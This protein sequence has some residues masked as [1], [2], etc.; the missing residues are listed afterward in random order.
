MAV[1]RPTA[2]EK[3]YVANQHKLFALNVI[4][5]VDFLFLKHFFYAKKRR[6]NSLFCLFSWTLRTGISNFATENIIQFLPNR[7]FLL[8]YGM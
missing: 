6:Q 7:I 2:G 8:L 3:R 1:A 4:L 5:I